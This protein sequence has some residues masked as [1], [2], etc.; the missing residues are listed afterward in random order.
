MVNNIVSYN[1][2]GFILFFFYGIK[3]DLVELLLV[4]VV[5]LIF[6]VICV[7]FG[8]IGNILVIIILNRIKV[9]EI[10][11]MDFYMI[12]LVIVDLGILLLVLLFIVMCERF[13]NDWLFGK[14]VCLYFFLVVEIFYGL[15]VW[16]IIVVGIECY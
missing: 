9:K 1:F 15:F 16:F 8:V 4:E 3:S 11:V 12:N 10:C 6:Y 14:I 5:K 13:F 7:L 2:I